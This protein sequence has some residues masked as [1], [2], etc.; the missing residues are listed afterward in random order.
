M[1]LGNWQ[2]D[3]VSG[4][5]FLV[6]GGTMFG[7]VPRALWQ[8]F[9]APDEHNR[10]R[11]ATRC[12]LARDGRHTVLIDTGYG[13]KTTAKERERMGLEAGDV[14][15]EG[16]A[17]LGV[18]PDDVD[19]VVLSHLHFDHAGGATRHDAT[20]RTVATFPRA[21]LVTQRGEWEVATSGAPELAAMYPQE[22]V[23]PLADTGRLELV[24]GDVEI[25]PGLRAWVT[26]GH[27]RWHMSLVLESGGQTALFL[28]DL[29]PTVAHARML[30][31]MSYEVDL[32]EI[33]RQKL[34]MLGHAADRG[35]LVVLDHDP[36][37][38]ACRLERAGEVD[39]RAVDVLEQ[40]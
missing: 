7:V 37:V 13:T 24:E 9:H 38:A 19:T 40:L 3:A 31:C 11:S 29:C 20:G 25:V 39:F 8:R 32:L 2:L 17:A 23:R 33:R 10:I 21:R 36:Q 27:T 12:L 15:V 22:H 26:P 34:R 18:A 30:W 14:L 4:G 35:W 1:Q 28:G 16:L 5:N 6:D